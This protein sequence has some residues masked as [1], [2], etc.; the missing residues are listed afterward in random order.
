MT[1]MNP[2]PQLVD[3]VDIDAVA[4]AVRSCPGVDDLAPGVLGSAASY[5]PGRTVAG[6]AVVGRRVTL[7]IRTVWGV[8]GREAAAQVRAAVRGLV[9]D[10]EVDVVV[11]DIADPVR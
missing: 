4:A 10:R 11:A 1:A 9:G 7:Q 2:Q 6:V 5:L 8:P 3:G